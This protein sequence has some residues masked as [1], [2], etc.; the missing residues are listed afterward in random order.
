LALPGAPA[1]VPGHGGFACGFFV[2]FG[3]GAGVGCGVA[4]AAAAAVGR[5]VGRGVGGTA[6]GVGRRTMGVA[7]GGGGVGGGL[8]V[9]PLGAVGVGLG[10]DEASVGAVGVGV[11]ATATTAPLG[12]GSLLA[13]AIGDG[14]TLEIGDVDGEPGTPDAPGVVGSVDPPADVVPDGVATGLASA[15]LDTAG[16]RSTPATP[17]SRWLGPPIPTARAN[18][19]NTRLRTPRATTR[20]AR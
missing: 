10:G 19:A 6:T 18:E 20:R 16:L 5:G 8:M 14:S 13:L 11:G 15:G 17:R 1:T 2:C 9:P 7:C 3:V 4:G 12:D